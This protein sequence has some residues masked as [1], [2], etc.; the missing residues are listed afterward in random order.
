MA[1]ANL[2]LNY[3]DKQ[4]M[5]MLYGRTLGHLL[6]QHIYWYTR[7]Y[8][9]FENESKIWIPKSTTDWH[10]EMPDICLKTIKRNVV[11]LEKIGIIKRQL[12]EMHGVHHK[13]KWYTLNVNVLHQDLRL[14]R[15]KFKTL[16]INKMIKN[17]QIGKQ[18]MDTTNLM[19]YSLS[20]NGSSTKLV[21]DHLIQA[22]TQHDLCS[23]EGQNV[24][25]EC[26]GNNGS[27]DMIFMGTKC[28]L[29]A[30]LRG[31]NVP[32]KTIYSLYIFNYKKILR[33]VQHV[34]SAH[35]K[36]Q[37]VTKCPDVGMIDFATLWDFY[38]QLNFDSYKLNR[39]RAKK[40]YNKLTQ[41]KKDVLFIQIV[42]KFFVR[43]LEKISGNKSDLEHAKYTTHLTT[44]TANLELENPFKPEKLYDE[45]IF[46]TTR[47]GKSRKKRNL[48]EQYQAKCDAENFDPA[49]EAV[50]K[51]Y[52]Y[53]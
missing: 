14:R 9:K 26:T 33:V 15:N 39:A 6:S 27:N 36:L 13:I 7:H 19:P 37:D 2:D 31:Q 32:I 4:E 49:A 43:H 12:F 45:L 28:P 46:A 23:Q 8:K 41:E 53:R 10:N 51:L 18:K 47:I 40:N 25:K 21:G 38:H 16:S 42:D 22:M 35:L 34:V 50:D 5:Y 48:S 3:K 11:T 1:N 17:K 20:L 52:R 30:V 44:F 24:P 29:S